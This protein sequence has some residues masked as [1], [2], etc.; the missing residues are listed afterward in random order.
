MTSTYCKCG[1]E[2]EFVKM[3]SGKMNPVN[4]K[5]MYTIVTNDG[6]IAQGRISHFATCPMAGEFR[7]DKSNGGN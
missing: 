2:I 4:V 3:K 5:P 6:N 7:K 1:A